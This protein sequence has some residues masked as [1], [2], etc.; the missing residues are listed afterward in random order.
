MSLLSG[1]RACAQ[2]EPST[3]HVDI[4]DGVRVI[5]IF[6][7]AWYHIWQ[8]SWLRAYIHIESTGQTLFNIEPLVRNGYIMVD[9]MLLI[10]GFLL[11]LPYARHMI[12]GAPRPSTKDFYIKR[13]LRILPTYWLSLLIVLVF[14]ALPAH[15]YKL[16]ARLW[17]DL[18]MHLTFTQVFSYET[19]IATELNVVLW[20]LAIEVQFYLIFP[21][22]AKVF[23][24]F[25]LWTWAVMTTA[26]VAFRYFFVLQLPDSQL[27]VNQLPTFLDVYANGMLAA[28]CYVH[29]ARS[30]KRNRWTR[31]AG[32][33][34]AIIMV[35]AIW[36]LVL[37]YNDT[38]GLRTYDTYELIRRHQS[39]YRFLFSAYVCVFILAA[40]NAGAGL[41]YLLSNKVV[42]VLS[43]ISFHYYIWHQFLAAKMHNDWHFPPSPYPYPNEVPDVPWQWLFTL[44]A[45]GF[46]LILS[47][48]LTYG[49]ERPIAK[50]GYAKWMNHRNKVRQARENKQPQPGAA[51][52]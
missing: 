18:W 9:V 19:Y 22:I 2:R 10:S 38:S 30:L 49:F 27:W 52:Q 29:L 26:G 11:F 32:T 14:F 4:L 37:D 15:N 45:F 48:V 47:L 5:A 24:K 33:A 20:T 8:Q 17:K 43:A 23:I 35:M 31:L 46:P 21:L 39:M 12:E 44:C 16:D 50:I 36:R 51:K 34:L 7:V 1:Y 25:P 42:Q 40:A 3:R 41:R 6:I 13:A 28:I